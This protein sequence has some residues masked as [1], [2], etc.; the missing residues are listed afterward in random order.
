M[1]FYDFEDWLDD[2]FD[3]VPWWGWLL[4]VAAVVA[5]CFVAHWL[6]YGPQQ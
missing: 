4:A 1:R 2:L 6:G 3:R 5:G